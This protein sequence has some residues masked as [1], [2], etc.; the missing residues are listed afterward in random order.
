MLAA[1]RRQ[2]GELA[3]IGVGASPARCGLHPRRPCV[4]G[5]RW[6]ASCHRSC[7]QWWSCSACGTQ[8]RRELTR[9][10][11][12]D[13]NQR[14]LR[15]ETVLG[16]GYTRTR[17]L[18][19]LGSAQVNQVQPNTEKRDITTIRLKTKYKIIFSV[20]IILYTE[21]F[22]SFLD[23]RFTGLFKTL[24]ISSSNFLIS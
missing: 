14:E 23:S 22:N 21:E 1:E 15:E 16:K 3:L 4:E 8:S 12:A 6:V 17:V 18:A 5:G 11:V 19:A 20:F 10:Q 13:R 24:N 2:A 7:S 9:A